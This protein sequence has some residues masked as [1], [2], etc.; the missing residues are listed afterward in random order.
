MIGVIK[1]LVRA[2]LPFAFYLATLWACVLGLRGR[3]MVPIG[4]IIV[5]AV[6]PNFWYQIHPFPFGKDT[7]DLLIVSCLLGMAIHK[8]M[9]VSSR[10]TVMLSLYLFFVYLQVWNTSIRYDLPLPFTTNNEVLVDFKNYAEMVMLYFVAFHAARDEKSQRQVLTICI[11]VYFLVVLREARSFQTPSAGFSYDSRAAGP[12]WIVGL[13]ANQFAAFVIHFGAIILALSFYMKEKKERWFLLATSI[14]ALKPL[15]FAYSR[16]AY[17]ATVAVL[18]VFGLI[19]K[20]SLLVVLLVVGVAWQV[21]L[22]QSVVERITTTENA[23]GQLESSAAERL[24]LWEKA[25]ELYKASP[26]VGSGLNSYGVSRIAGSWTSVHNLYLQTMAE[27]GIVGL[28]F[29]IVVMLCALATGIRLLLSGRTPME[30]GLG[31]G[32]F[33]C[34]IA[35]IVTN[36]FGDRWSYYSTGAL[37]WIFW[38]IADRMLKNHKVKVPI[39]VPSTVAEPPAVLTAS[40]A[41]QTP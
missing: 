11:A 2:M 4:V 41:E 12:F 35:T 38:G 14:I 7:G 30:K 18:F 23:D 32:F 40:R 37:F 19:K 28:L 26:I 20:R 6:L 34:M 33:G 27:Q 36:I 13:G 1:D 25:I 21:I 9:T 22:P 29:L 24:V 8:Q 3:V 10:Q 5:C 31:L 15:F 17:L 16:G 39:N